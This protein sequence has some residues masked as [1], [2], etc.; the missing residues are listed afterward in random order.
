MQQLERDPNRVALIGFGRM[1]PPT[2]RIFEE[3]GY[4][5][6]VI[7]DIKDPK[8]LS[9]REAIEGAGI[10][11]F[12]VFPIENIVKIIRATRDVFTAEHRVL[13]NASLKNP[14]GPGY[15]IL[16]EKGV[17]ICST[18]PL[19]KEDQPFRGQ[20]V[21]IAPFGHH[22]QQAT[23]I[24]EKVYQEAGMVLT[25]LDF[26]RH[27]LTL[28]FNQFY[29]HLVNRA[30]TIALAENGVDVEA[31]DRISTANSRLSSLAVWRTSVQPSE[32][33]AALI[34]G[35]L[36]QPEGQKIV[37]DLQN[38]I[39]RIVEESQEPGRLEKT[40]AETVSL[41]DPTGQF[42]L[43]MNEETTTILERLANLKLQSVTLEIDARKNRVGLLYRM[44]GVFT[45]GEI[46]L[47]A[48]DSHTD[49]KVLR[50]AVGIKSGTLTP[51][52]I[53]GLK[54]LGFRDISLTVS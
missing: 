51:K 50:F 24:A 9:A 12:S 44:L 19:C 38:A 30:V 22:P 47:S 52:V 3:A 42:R 48:I 14:L 25:R 36:G 40:F 5:S 28:A 13:D 34:R 26:D 37:S 27:D 10:V 1:G 49:G 15:E 17:S 23:I 35:L 45:R 7:S 53:K 16:D 11:F 21:V 31:L 18:H 29:P 6:I 2:R 8:T 43:V 4:S 54:R 32:I 41:L 33:S 39:A 20:N 46:D